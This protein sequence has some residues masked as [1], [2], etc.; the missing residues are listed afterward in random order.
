MLTCIL[1][2]VPCRGE[3][4][5]DVTTPGEVGWV[6]FYL[7]GSLHL[8]QKANHLCAGSG[9]ADRQVSHTDSWRGQ[10]AKKNES[11]CFL[12]LWRII[13]ASRSVQS[14]KRVT[15][16]ISVPWKR[17]ALGCVDVLL[18]RFVLGAFAGVVPVFARFRGCEGEVPETMR[19]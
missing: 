6:L 5:Y 4:E 18:L 14:I 8:S 12:S 10:A 13:S 2:R 17:L 11:A 3:R 19:S 7:G 16:S 9:R 1:S 15:R